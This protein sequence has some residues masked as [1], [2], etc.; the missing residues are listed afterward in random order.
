MHKALRA[1]YLD[2][3][4]VITYV[5]RQATPVHWEGPVDASLVF[6]FQSNDI[7]LDWHAP[8][9]QFLKKI[10]DAVDSPGFTVALCY[11][12]GTPISFP[13]GVNPSGVVSFG[14]K[15]THDIFPRTIETLPLDALQRDDAAKRA[16][17]Q[18][19][20]TTKAAYGSEA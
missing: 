11:S 2:R 16:L 5:P 20:K 17:W 13:L 6:V 19:L 1:Q 3:L 14:R 9:Y 18:A 7:H 8:I 4:G 15:L 10:M 12:G